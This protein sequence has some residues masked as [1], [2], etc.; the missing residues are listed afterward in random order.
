MLQSRGSQRVGHDL[1]TKQ[2][3]VKK[4][5]LL[6]LLAFLARD[7]GSPQ[8]SQS[9][10]GLTYSSLLSP[11]KVQTLTHFAQPAKVLVLGFCTY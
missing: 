7:G 11:R 10:S 9:L 5:L 6:A 4:S 1:A 3:Q 8:G 2:Q